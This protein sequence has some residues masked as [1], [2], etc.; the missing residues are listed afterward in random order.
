MT[1][2]TIDDILNEPP[3]TTYEYINEKGEECFHTPRQYKLHE[4]QKTHS[5]KGVKREEQ[6]AQ[7]ED[8]LISQGVYE[9]DQFNYGYYVL[10]ENSYAIVGKSFRIDCYALEVSDKF[11]T[12]ATN[13]GIVENLDEAVKYLNKINNKII[14]LARK[15]RTVARKIKNHWQTRLVFNHEKGEIIAIK[16][17]E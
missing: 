17:M 3:K 7:Y 9:Y 2:Y 8:W 11:H 4:F 14:N 1:Q 6:L 13:N 16:E 15:K 5:I 12:I 10:D